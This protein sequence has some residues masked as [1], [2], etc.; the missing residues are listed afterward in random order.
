MGRLTIA[1]LVAAV[2]LGSFVPVAPAQVTPPP[3]PPARASFWPAIKGAPA[4]AEWYSDVPWH[5]KLGT[6]TGNEIDEALVLPYEALGAT[7]VNFCTTNKLSQ[8]DCMIETG[9]NSILGIY[10]I[11]TPYD[12]TDGKITAAKYCKSTSQ[13][14]SQP[15]I[16]VKLALAMFWTRSNDAGSVLQLQQ[17]PFGNDLN[18]DPDYGGYVITDGTA[19]APQM[20]WYMSHYC[21]LQLTSGGDALDP[22]CYADYFTSMNDGFNILPMKDPTKWPDAFP[23]SVSPT[24][25]LTRNHCQPMLTTCTLAMAGFRSQ[26][27]AEY[28][29]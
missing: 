13:P 5:Q 16:E 2:T 9:I 15:C 14:S 7:E 20:P 18:A 6:S 21:D 8:E 22:V 29:E 24:P 19:Y 11:D 12:Q 17:R 10:R 1:G 23:W 4:V 28:P 27:R 25:N 3:M 26:P